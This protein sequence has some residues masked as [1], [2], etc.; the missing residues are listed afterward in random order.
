VCGIVLA[1]KQGLNEHKGIHTRNWPCPWCRVIAKPFH[2]SRKAVKGHIKERHADKF[3]AFESEYDKIKNEWL[4]TNKYTSPDRPDDEEKARLRRLIASA[5]DAEKAEEQPQ[6]DEDD[7]T[8]KDGEEPQ[9]EAAKTGNEE[10][11]E[12]VGE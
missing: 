7:Q 12:E 6:A 10:D 2:H 1:N 9:E 4:E 11:K 3:E 5:E 8:E